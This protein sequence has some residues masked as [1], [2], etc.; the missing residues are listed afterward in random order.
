MAD[1]MEIQN[2]Y[3]KIDTS[4]LSNF[5]AV[6][7]RSVHLEWALDF[8]GNQIH[9]VAS[10]SMEVLVDGTAEALFDS[11]MLTITS[12]QVNQVTTTH[13]IGP[14][15]TALGQSI[16]VPIPPALRS[17]GSTFVVSFR[18]STSKDA[19]AIQWLDPAATAG[20]NHPY[21]FT[22]SQAIHARSLF[23]CQDAPGAKLTYTADVTSPQ[24]C[25]VLMSALSQGTVPSTTLPG[26]V[27]HKWSQPVITSTYLIALAAGHL[28]SSDISPRVR[29]WSEPEVIDKVRD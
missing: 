25:T 21:A 26:S 4:T 2:A 1:F 9:G 6:A 11:R 17:A 12:V 7:Q 13:T 14:D 10:L 19:P 3:S 5:L 15:N 22:Q 28:T 24:W 16:T 29:V 23:P 27:V 18:Y 8:P 20:G